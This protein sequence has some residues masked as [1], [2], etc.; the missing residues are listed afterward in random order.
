[1]SSAAALSLGTIAGSSSSKGLYDDVLPLPS[2]VV[3]PSGNDL[4]VHDHGRVQP[5]AP[6]DPTGVSRRDH[7][8]SISVAGEIRVEMRQ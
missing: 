4:T 2:V 8:V 6:L 1:M 5:A 3:A 7:K